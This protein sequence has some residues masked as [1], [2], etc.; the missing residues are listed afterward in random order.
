MERE[1]RVKE[2]SSHHPPLVLPPVPPPVAPPLG[3]ACA[4]AR[5]SLCR[6]FT[7]TGYFSRR[8]EDSVE[9]FLKKLSGKTTG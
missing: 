8:Q 2:S 6:W 7:G 9:I 3:L 4:A 1:G 5:V